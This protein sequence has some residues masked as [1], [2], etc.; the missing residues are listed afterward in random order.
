MPY[1]WAF[2]GVGGGL[3]GVLFVLLMAVVVGW[4]FDL[5]GQIKDLKEMNRDLRSSIN[6]MADT[7]ESWTPD[8]QKRRLKRP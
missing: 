1:E 8:E 2:N 5:R 7:I 3:Q 6:R 4:Y